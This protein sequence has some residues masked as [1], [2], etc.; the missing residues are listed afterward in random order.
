M[1]KICVISF[2]Q[3][4]TDGRVLRQIESLSRVGHVTTIGYGTQPPFS[5]EHYSIP[6]S[7]QYLPL[8][9]TGIVSL[10]TRR[11]DTAY[12]KTKA[13][14][15]STSILQNL[16][17]D[18]VVFNDVQTIGLSKIVVGRSSI[19]IDM[20]EYAPEEMS[21][22]WRFRLLL[23]RYYQHLCSKYLSNATRA[24]TVSPSIAAEFEK[25]LGIKFDVIR[26]S[27]KYYE[28]SATR[29]ESGQ[30]NLV[31]A[32]LASKGRHLEIMIEAVR[33]LPN[34]QLDLYL[35]P[36]PRQNS[37]YRQ[38]QKKINKISNVRLCPPVPS[39]D[40]VSTLNRYDVGLLVINPSNFS[41]ANCLP[42]KL[43]E[44]IQA[45]LMVISGPTPDV[46]EIVNQYDIGEVIQNF[47]S[48][49]L[50]KCLM[51][52]SEEK[53]S[54]CKT[55]ADSASKLVDFKFDGEKLSSLVGDFPLHN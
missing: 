27:C 46:K 5:S 29:A 42:N 44:Y 7:S 16:D 3:L 24:I 19:V 14:Q 41:L 10:L 25:T 22:D 28:L 34:M 1:L 47:S 11:F 20:H 50:R 40:L 37:Y 21:D 53:I 48:E 38:L 51:A 36:A 32:G 13:V 33:E 45:R 17:F 12:S 18:V 30:I 26:N 23:R 4:S 35:V 49:D 39:S 8:T 2:S 52:L 43:F 6:S 31:H 54:E 9:I 15:W 55:N